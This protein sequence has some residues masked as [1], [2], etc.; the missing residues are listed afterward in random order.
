MNM[1][2]VNCGAAINL[3]VKFCSN[4]GLKQ[5][6]D[7]NDI[8]ELS[9]LKKVNSVNLEK[10]IGAS[11][12]EEIVSNKKEIVI[13]K[14]KKIF[15]YSILFFSIAI[16]VFFNYLNKADSIVPKKE[17]Y[18]AKPSEKII[19]KD[20]DKWSVGITYNHYSDGSCASS[21]TA[22]CI[23]E[24]DYKELCSLAKDV[25]QQSLKIRAVNAGFEEK[26]LLE[27]GS[28]QRITIFYGKN[29]LGNEKCFTIVTISGIVNGTSMRK[30]IQGAVTSFVK[31]NKGE[32]LVSHF[33]QF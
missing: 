25:T 8:D 28:L 33:S 18:S 31:S 4:C 1:F 9:N 23:S 27:G 6:L 12:I 14:Y 15:H 32:I 30:D 19:A 11:N 20:S 22:Q 10:L 7:H 2:C 13:N 16:L 21:A 17:F 3:N 24:S 29:N 26:S 5:E